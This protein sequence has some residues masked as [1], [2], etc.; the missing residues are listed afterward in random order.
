MDSRE[1]IRLLEGEGWWL[2]R[3]N[4]SHHIFRHGPSAGST[5]VPHPRKDVRLGTVKS[6]E[7]QS[8]VALRR[9]G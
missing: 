4:G 6:I 9:R 1:I 3:V 2:D 7:R 5:T 8:G